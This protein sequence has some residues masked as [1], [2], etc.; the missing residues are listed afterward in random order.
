MEDQH[1]YLKEGSLLNNRY[2]IGGVLGHGGFGITYVGQDEQLN[3]KVAIKE[4]LP[5]DF[6]TRSEGSMEVKTY[7]GGNKEQYEY[8][9]KRFLDEARTL[10]KYNDHPCIVSTLNYFEANNT[11]YL[12]MEFLDGISLKEYLKR[13]GG[14]LT[15]KESVSIMMPVMDALKEVHKD[16]IIHRDV[17][18]DNIYITVKGSVKLI[19]FGAARYAFGEKSQSLSVI[20][21][22]GYAPPEQYSSKGKQGPFT[23]I[24]AVAAT[25]YKMVHGG[26]LLEAVDRLKTPEL[27]FD[28]SIDKTMQ[29][30]LTK[31]LAVDGGKRYQTMQAFQN[32]IA[33]PQQV[34]VNEKELQDINAGNTTVVVKKSKKT[35]WFV[36]LSLVLIAALIAT[37]IAFLNKP[38][39]VVYQT[40]T[41][42]ITSD[43]IIEYDDRVTLNPANDAFDG[44]ATIDVVYIDESK[45]DYIEE[46]GHEFVSK[47]VHMEGD[48]D[49]NRNRDTSEALFTLSMKY[50]KEA[51]DDQIT[52]VRL[53]KNDF[54]IIESRVYATE[55]RVEADIDELDTYAVVELD[56][57][58][59]IAKVYPI[60]EGMDYEFFNRDASEWSYELMHMTLEEVLQVAEPID[61]NSQ[62]YTFN[63]FRMFF[64]EAGNPYDMMVDEPCVFHNMAIGEEQPNPSFPEGLDIVR[65]YN[66]EF[67]MVTYFYYLEPGYEIL[68]HYD[69]PEYNEES[70][71]KM[72][73]VQVMRYDVPEVQ[74]DGEGE[75]V[76]DSPYK[77]GFEKGELKDG[78]IYGDLTVDSV[79]D[80]LGYM[81][82]FDGLITVTGRYYYSYSTDM[83]DEWVENIY[84]EVPNHLLPHAVEDTEDSYFLIGPL[85]LL[86][87]DMNDRYPTGEATLVLDGY[88]YV[89]DYP[90]DYPRN[91]GVMEVLS[92][93]PD[94]GLPANDIPAD[95][96]ET[97]R[98]QLLI[99]AE[100][101]YEGKNTFF[102]SRDGK[103][104]ALDLLSMDI[105]E[106]LDMSGEIIS[107]SSDGK[108]NH[109]YSFNGLIVIA[110]EGGEKATTVA[111]QQQGIE[112][113]GHMLG[114]EADWLE[115]EYGEPSRIVTYDK[116]GVEIGLYEYQL[117]ATVRERLYFELDD[118]GHPIKFIAS[119]F[120][121]DQIEYEEGTYGLILNMMNMTYEELM[122]EFGDQASIYS[123]SPT[124]VSV[125]F[126]DY[127]LSYAAYTWEKLQ[128]TRPYRI[129]H[130]STQNTMLGM[131]PDK[132]YGEIQEI[133]ATKGEFMEEGVMGRRFYSTYMLEGWTMTIHEQTVF[134]VD[135]YFTEFYRYEDGKPYSLAGKYSL[136]EDFYYEEGSL[137][138]GWVIVY[139]GEGEDKQRIVEDNDKTFL[140]VEGRSSWSGVVRYD[141][142][143]PF[144]D[145]MVFEFDAAART[146]GAVM[147]G[148]GSFYT[149]FGMTNHGEDVW[150]H[151]IYIVDF[152]NESVEIIVNG[153]L[154]HVGDSLA[155]QDPDKDW[156]PFS[157]QPC[158]VV[159][160]GNKDSNCDI[161]LDNLRVYA[162]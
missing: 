53:D 52:I 58:L 4:Y 100:G 85:E 72:L 63:G 96:E 19:D 109:I 88:V 128:Q 77:H 155:V 9:L 129:T 160:T 114:M 152:S 23:D 138:E 136:W 147:L 139:S 15:F 16:G 48:F 2:R 35:K 64:D 148:N 150:N 59:N 84:F 89:Y 87:D 113:A 46:E 110:P 17:S 61:K 156:S 159:D 94:N 140:K 99:E 157:T 78:D 104:W 79:S 119:E 116:E 98:E 153:N 25:I 134:E 108:G 38:T 51:D 162:Y 122:T 32:A 10:A 112:Y 18:P 107:Q 8:G 71:G 62:Y 45:F 124:Y 111:I 92:V 65:Y 143:E 90:S 33:A 83:N 50:D 67:E 31:A 130:S 69:S 68:I 145:K 74:G 6:A 43:E 135:P 49:E 86:K 66:D 7:S 115:S 132:S 41:Y 22:P 12:V 126:Q 161:S 14:T 13:K 42:K 36:A 127:N 5:G 158:I 82:F 144:A 118:A 76:A 142:A 97:L 120:I 146:T 137:P 106:I 47:P 102:F 125:S 37:T 55:H 105:D 26:N 149:C 154:V 93:T 91:A 27:T 80:E 40:V 39:E 57:S 3:M 60:L 95:N 141:F 103:E 20:L 1:Y 54:E 121:D 24:Y 81:V 30:V 75:Y 21:K 73:F 101:F 70:T 29:Y 117:F 56:E 123:V 34:T 11:A 151:Y 44:K 28:S 133:A 131:T